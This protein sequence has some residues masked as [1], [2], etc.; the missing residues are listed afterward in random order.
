MDSALLTGL[1]AGLA[2]GGASLPHCAGMCGPLA[3]ATCGTAA[4]GLAYQAGRLAGYALL[5]GA[6]GAVGGRLLAFAP[7]AAA[8]VA[9]SLTLAAALFWAAARAL[10]GARAAE[11]IGPPRS[12]GGTREPAAAGGSSGGVVALG[13]RPRRP[14]VTARVLGR[15]LDAPFALGLATALLPC[16]AL[17]SGLLVAAGTGGAAA[18]A[19]AM[20][21]F[22]VA[23]APA[24]VAA[25]WA[26]ARLRALP[27]RT[28][29]RG[30]RLAALALALGGVVM[31]A[32][33]VPQLRALGG[34]APVG[35]TCHDAG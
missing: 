14:P 33:A 34:G 31:A 22:A 9:L 21:G 6:A 4:R 12:V 3:A 27:D 2:A 17:A 15:L 7:A 29:G 35:A 20:L 30:L 28:R 24:L 8:Q 11:V 32:R 10:R 16:G 23:S 25:A 5:G 1:V 13:R 26:V 18:G 19:A